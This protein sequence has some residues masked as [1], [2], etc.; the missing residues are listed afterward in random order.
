MGGHVTAKHFKQSAGDCCHRGST[1]KPD[2]K[3]IILLVDENLPKVC[4]SCC[5]CC[6]CQRIGAERKGARDLNSGM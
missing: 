2:E 6:R 5:C 3:N 1:V 4:F